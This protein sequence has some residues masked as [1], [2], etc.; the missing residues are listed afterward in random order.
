[1]ADRNKL[2]D[3]KDQSVKKFNAELAF[4]VNILYNQNTKDA[5]FC[6]IKDAFMVVKN[7]T[8]ELIVT[9]VGSYI[10]K[11]RVNIKAGQVKQLL[12]NDYSDEIKEVSAR[13]DS[14]NVDEIKAIL[15]KV[16]QYWSKF[17]QIE[18]DTIVKRIQSMLAHYASVLAAE[19]EL[20]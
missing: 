18:Q 15:D 19:K 13:P 14:K 3:L 2:M 4:L 17:N 20:K 7:E 5:D 6:T 11:Y 8:P 9:T 10:W 12:D 1:M 16:K